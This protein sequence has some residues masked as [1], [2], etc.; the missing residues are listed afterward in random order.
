MELQKRLAAAG[1]PL[2]F[3]APGCYD[4]MLREF[5][6]FHLFAYDV[7]AHAVQDA[8][9]ITIVLRFGLQLDH[10]KRQYFTREQIANMDDEL[11]AF[12]RKAAE[13]CKQKLKSDYMNMIKT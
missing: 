10:E 11:T 5:S 1:L 3:V 9:G 8:N 4:A 13:D 7:Q 12:F 2:R 6:R